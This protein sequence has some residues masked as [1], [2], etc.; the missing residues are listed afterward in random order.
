MT[1]IQD[2]QEQLR[3]HIRAR[4]GRG[5]LTG[6]GLAEEADLPPGHLS[7]F[8]N[9]RRGLSLESMDRL[10]QALRIGVLD[11]VSREEVQRRVRPR[12][13]AGVEPVALVS[14]EHAA[15]ARFRDDQILETRN[16][17]KAFLRRLRP[18][19]DVDRSDWQRFVVIKLDGRNSRGFFPRSVAATL[20]VDRYYNSLE[21]YRRFHPNLY[22]VRMGESCV[23]AQIS[24]CDNCLMLRPREPR[25]PI[26]VV[27]IEAGRS[28]SDYIVGRVCHVG[29]EV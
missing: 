4:M 27:R 6:K 1:T 25:A 18:R 20:L 11:L 14:P 19:A 3:V 12:G 28:Y 21:P 23:A 16:F 9:S 26:E 17:N 7:N 29:L 13:I 8:L 5:E 22:A 15:L 10:L 24:V 2:L